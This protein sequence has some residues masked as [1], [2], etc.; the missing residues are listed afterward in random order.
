MEKVDL[1]QVKYSL[2]NPEDCGFMDCIDEEET[3]ERDGYFHRW[4]DIEIESPESHNF[5]L[6]TVALIEDNETGR[7]ELIDIDCLRF[8]NRK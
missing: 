7:M 4:T 5:I 8:I 1:R 3:K 6:K 2:R